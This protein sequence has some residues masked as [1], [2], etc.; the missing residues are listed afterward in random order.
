MK[1]LTLAAVLTVVLSSWAPAQCK[2]GGHVVRPVPGPPLVGGHIRWQPGPPIPWRGGDTEC[3]VSGVSA[4]AA[5]IAKSQPTAVKVSVGQQVTIDGRFFGS[6]PGAVLVQIGATALPAE[7][8][9]W[10]STQAVVVLPT[11]PLQAPV[12]ATIVVKTAFGRVADQSEVELQPAL[13]APPTPAENPAP[14][15]PTVSAGQTVTLDGR[16]FGPTAG[17]VQVVIGALTLHARV[18]QWGETSVQA[19]LPSLAFTNAVPASVQIMTA[20]GQLAEQVDITLQP[21]SAIEAPA[22]PAGPAFAQ[23]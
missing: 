21:A 8:V 16:A 15:R 13:A 7:V 6:Q 3:L 20:T 22:A 18:L 10:S 14:S 17:R 4:S 23:R 2:S 1:T 12:R 5:G 9:R 19:T 11:M